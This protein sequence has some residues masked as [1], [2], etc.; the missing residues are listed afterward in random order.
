[1]F[2][3]ISRHARLFLRLLY[4]HNRANVE[5]RGDFWLKILGLVLR[6]VIGVVF[7]Y[8]LFSH[9]E[10][11]AGWSRAEVM[12]LYALAVAPRGLLQLFCNGA[13]QLR[14]YIWRGQFDQF[15]TRPLSPVFQTLTLTMSIEGLGTLAVGGAA[16]AAG[17]AALSLQWSLGAWL[18]LVLVLIGGTVLAT[19][20]DVGMHALVFWSRD[21]GQL[22]WFVE[23]STEFAQYPVALYHRA[24]QVALST[25]LPFAF[26]SYYPL[27]HLLDKPGAS[28][29]LAAIS[30][31]VGFAFAFLMS[32]IWHAGLMRYQSA[33]S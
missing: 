14:N 22:Q 4:M 26:I 25:L 10:T 31:L 24:L 33:G 8:A 20:L 17:Y 29:M 18:Y 5:Y 1:M 9:V 12:M 16:F 23:Q 21:A 15:L 27:A 3:R 32:R 30:P 6:N 7:V 11:L 13:W 2:K 19:A 28:A